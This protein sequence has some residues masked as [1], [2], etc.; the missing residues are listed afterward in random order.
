M[1][2][3][4]RKKIIL[5]LLTLVLLGVGVSTVIS[6]GFAE[7]AITDLVKGQIVSQVDA[8]LLRVDDWLSGCATD[9][10]DLAGNTELGRAVKYYG[11]RDKANAQLAKVVENRPQ[12]LTVAMADAKGNLIACNNKAILEKK[13]NISDRGYFKAA[14][15]GEATIS[16]VIKSR[17]TGEP[18][19][20]AASPMVADKKIQ[21]LVLATVSVKYLSKQYIDG[22]KVGGNGY[23]FVTN[24][25]GMIMAHPDK[26][27]I[28][29][30]NIN[31]HELGKAFKASKGGIVSYTW[32]GEK[33][34]AGFARV[35]K[36]GWTLCVATARDHI[37]A[38]VK[39]MRKVLL[40][41]GVFLVLLVGCSAWVVVGRFVVTP[42]KHVS[43]GLDD[44]TRGE[45]DLTRRLNIASR[46]EIGELGMRFD[47]FL[48]Q[49]AGVVREI[50]ASAEA[51]GESSTELSEV[52]RELSG[53]ADAA[54]ERAGTVAG[55]SRAVSENIGGV[56]AAIEESAANANMVAA[57]AE[58]MTATIGEVA[59]GTTR[60][61]E[62]SGSAVDEAAKASE[63]M[64]SLSRSSGEID[65][66]SETITEISEQTNLLALNATIE[67]ARAGEAGKGFAVVAG[68]IKSLALQT[69]EATGDIK[70]KITDIQAATQGAVKGIDR[71]T[72]VIGDIDGIVGGIAAAIEE[73]SATTGEIAA[74]IAQV[75][76]GV[77]GVGEKV[78]ENAGVIE[79]M[80]RDI[81]QVNTASHE[82]SS[83][84]SRV[85]NGARTLM[86]QARQLNAQVEKFKV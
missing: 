30:Y 83:G 52:S 67:A 20:V 56:A 26:K 55:A 35:E 54:S 81:E 51:V 15:N 12:Y 23:A 38:P 39:K 48:E 46:D 31:D 14:M 45:G 36:R 13:I 7:K 75:S 65:A 82:I 76:S 60:A 6:N 80:S 86:E 28:L 49:L 18:V 29:A 85:E 40:F 69:A 10:R 63:L 71:I 4:L 2:W 44:I 16:K 68:E 21:G 3:N 1:K 72:G 64:E 50:A 42:V 77:T 66:I 84:S 70:D 37:L 24:S 5:P 27:L 73:Q 33:K 19:F 41:I 25:E 62:V 47:A 61:S 11:L 17:A 58:E 59:Q 53:N 8:T 78:V 32:N 22:I 34:I 43:D 79:E 57:A 9:I 74:N